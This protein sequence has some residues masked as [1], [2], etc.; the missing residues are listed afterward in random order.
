MALLTPV[1]EFIESHGALTIILQTAILLV[2]RSFVVKIPV[3]V[4]CLSADAIECSRARFLVWNTILY[5]SP[6]FGSS[7]VRCH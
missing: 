7:R 4:R 6:F 1:F 2:I 5:K 3:Y